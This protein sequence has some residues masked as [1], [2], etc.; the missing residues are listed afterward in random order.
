MSDPNT[1]SLMT[2]KD[3]A[4]ELCRVGRSLF[5]RGYVHGSTGNISVRLP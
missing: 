2:V 1:P 3:H 4:R 5:D